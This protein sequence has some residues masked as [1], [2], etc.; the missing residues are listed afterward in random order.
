MLTGDLFVFCQNIKQNRKQKLKFQ[1]SETLIS[2]NWSV[3]MECT[4]EEI[5]EKRRIALERL[6]AKKEALAKANESLTKT[7]NSVVLATSKKI[8]TNPYQS[9]RTASHPYANKVP[10]TSTTAAKQPTSIPVN[11]ISCSCYMISDSRFEVNN[12]GFS[13]QLINIFKTI[14]SRSYGIQSDSVP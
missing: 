7:N 10:T 1:N 8:S 6:K 12:S 14:P 5:A 4:A 2:H 3:I 13:S 11:V 9:T